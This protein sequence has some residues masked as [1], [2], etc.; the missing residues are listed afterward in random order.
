MCEICLSY[1]LIFYVSAVSDCIDDVASELYSGHVSETNFGYTC[2]AW[3][4]FRPKFT[5]KQFPI[6]GSVAEASNYCRNFDDSNIPWCFTTDPH[7]EYGFCD[8]RICF[9]MLYIYIYI[10]IIQSINLF[11]P[12]GLFLP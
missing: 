10:Y 9:G 2:Q 1:L 3:A 8:I 12:K 5:D 4:H 11:M 6:D 7:V